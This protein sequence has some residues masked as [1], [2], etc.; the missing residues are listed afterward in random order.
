VDEP[1]STLAIECRG[2]RFTYPATGVASAEPALDGVSFDVRA[3]E[4]LGVLG[5]NGGGK[6]TLLKLILGELEPDAGTVLV[7]GV[8]PARARRAGLVGYLPQRIGAGR[9]WPISVRQAVAMGAEVRLAPWKRPGARQR[10]AVDRAIELVGIA[11][12]ASRPVG[13]LSGGQLQRAMIARAIAIEPEVLV[14]DEPTVG[15]DVAGQRRFSELIERLHRELRVTVVTVSHELTT[16]A[17]SSDRVA[18]LRQSLHFHDAPQG[19][20]PEVLAEVFRHDVEAVLGGEVHV[21]AHAAAD[22]RDPSHGRAPERDRGGG[23]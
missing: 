17:A 1:T 22:C 21:D 13:R 8:T 7:C 23:S 5:P 2:V 4:R 9:A 6:S 19:L 14:L 12:L 20:T 10:E 3:G 15:V 18:C 11:D 16:I